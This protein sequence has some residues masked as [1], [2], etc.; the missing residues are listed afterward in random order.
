MRREGASEVFQERMDCV[1]QVEVEPQGVQPE[2]R[3]QVGEAADP[4]VVEDE[5]VEQLQVDNEVDITV[6]SAKKSHYLPYFF[7][8]NLSHPEENAV[9]NPE[10]PWNKKVPFFLLVEVLLKYRWTRAKKCPRP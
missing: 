5:G 8:I 10:S 4:G 1:D 3:G 2:G 7:S 9:Q 6:N